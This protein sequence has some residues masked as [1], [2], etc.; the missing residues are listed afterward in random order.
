MFPTKTTTTATTI[1]ISVDST[2]NAVRLAHSMILVANEKGTTKKEHE[3][4]FNARLPC[5]MCAHIEVRPSVL[6]SMESKVYFICIPQDMND[7]VMWFICK[8]CD[9][10]VDQTGHYN[11][12]NSSNKSKRTSEK[13]NSQHVKQVQ[14][15]FFVSS[16]NLPFPRSRYILF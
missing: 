2:P 13:K 6:Y 9:A 4:K 8:R 1:G 3:R 12:N 15:F 14:H 11:S 10:D 5:K 16:H 7:K